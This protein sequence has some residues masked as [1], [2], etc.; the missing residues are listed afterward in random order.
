MQLDRR[1]LL[2]SGLHLCASP[3]V[4]VNNNE[5]HCELHNSRKCT[6]Q[7]MIKFSSGLKKH[8]FRLKILLPVVVKC[9]RG[10]T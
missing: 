7:H 2:F 3:I 6:V 1:A 10:Q 4:E 9:G 8:N 5:E